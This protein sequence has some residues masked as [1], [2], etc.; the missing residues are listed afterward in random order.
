MPKDSLVVSL[1]ARCFAKWKVWPNEAKAAIAVL[2][3]VLC[4]WRFGRPELLSEQPINY[5]HYRL[6]VG[7]R[8]V[9]I[10]TVRGDILSSRAVSLL[11]S[12]CTRQ[13]ASFGWRRVMTE[14]VGK[15]C[16]SS[17]GDLL[18]KELV[19]TYSN[20]LVRAGFR[21]WLALSV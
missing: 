6:P 2:A 15:V 21:T 14:R 20:T 5:R 16:S 9:Q 11:V 13:A 3:G 18:R 8:A 7:R 4:P 17:M 19:A 10:A 1:F 12:P